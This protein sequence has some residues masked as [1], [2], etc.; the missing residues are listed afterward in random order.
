[1]CMLLCVASVWG[2][3]PHG[4]AKPTME[5]PTALQLGLHGKVDSVVALQQYEGGNDMTVQEAWLFDAEGKLTKHVKRGFG[6]EHVTLYPRV[7][8]VNNLQKDYHDADGDLLERRCYTQKGG[9]LSSSHYIYAEGGALAAVM[10]YEYSADDE[11][12]VSGHTETYYNTA[13]NIVV[14]EQ[15]TADAV[16]LMQEH[17]KYNKHGDLVQREQRFIDGAEEDVTK[18]T[19]K[20]KYD[21]QGNWLRCQYF[22]N[23]KKL[24][25]TTRTIAY[26]DKE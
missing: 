25:T 3:H 1:M 13:G 16:L 17:R 10:T 24:Y 6:G 23:G 11:N 7:T 4:S 20:Y 12:V 2:Q 8:A 9:L 15:Y 5:Q 14:I 19:R 21:K 18:E 26:R 22:H